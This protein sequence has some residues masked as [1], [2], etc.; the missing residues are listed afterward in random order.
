MLPIRCLLCGYEN[1]PHQRFCGMCGSPLSTAAPPQARPVAPAPPVKVAPPDRQPPTCVN[2]PSFLGLSQ[3]SGSMDYL[4]DEEAG[5]MHWR[6]LLL[7][8]ALIVAAASTVWLI[9]RQK[10][11]WISAQIEQA[12][13]SISTILGSKP[14]AYSQPGQPMSDSATA[15]EQPAS[16]PPPAPAPDEGSAKSDHPPIDLS[17][18]DEKPAEL[19]VP[20]AAEKME[21]APV[22]D[23]K[24]D[25]L[26]EEG[27]DYLYGRH[28][29]QDCRRA[30]S[31]LMSAADAANSKAQG[32]LGTM[33]ATGHCVPHDLPAAYH[34]FSEAQQGDPHNARIEQDLRLVWKQMTP[35]QQRVAGRQPE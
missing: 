5:R 23:A 1:H 12:R 14:A 19:P 3:P 11:G 6:A 18:G 4:L 35:Q 30:R 33:Y 34:W 13:G 31:S 10:P 8:V 28:V 29:R 24:Q 32:I 9:R 15:T 21:N 2:G 16:Q 20:S 25:A 26:V 22:E 17:A 27:Q 7:A